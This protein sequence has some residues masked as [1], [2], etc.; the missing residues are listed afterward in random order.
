MPRS[1]PP[2]TDLIK[3]AFK[4]SAA[5]LDDAVRKLERRVAA[6][7]ELS[8][9]L[10]LDLRVM[11]AE[12]DKL[13]LMCGNFG[14]EPH[15]M[16]RARALLD[17]YDPLARLRAVKLD[18]I[19]RMADLCDRLLADGHP[20]DVAYV[21]ELASAVVGFEDELACEAETYLLAFAWDVLAQCEAGLG[22]TIEHTHYLGAHARAL[23][24]RLPPAPRLVAEAS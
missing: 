9:E 17:R 8:Q 23:A 6:L 14:R 21:R 4:R 7:G 22:R 2:R 12:C 24:S 11:L 18:H 10:C 20:P 3:S 16:R 19:D 13:R 5:C 15:M 1:R